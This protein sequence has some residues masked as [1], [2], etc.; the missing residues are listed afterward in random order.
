MDWQLRAE[1]SL[2][3]YNRD[4]DSETRAT[5]MLLICDDDKRIN[6]AAQI[7]RTTMWN[8]KQ[9]IS[10]KRVNERDRPVKYVRAPIRLTSYYE[11]AYLTTPKLLRSSIYAIEEEEKVIESF[12]KNA[13]NINDPKSGD[14]E[15]WP[16]R[17]F[18]NTTTDL[19]KYIYCFSA[20]KALMDLRNN[21]DLSIAAHINKLNYV[22]ILPKEDYP[23]IQMYPDVV[24]MEGMNIYEYRHSQND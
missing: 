15:D 2:F 21:I 7:I 16:C 10:S 3:Y 9:L 19:L 24:E 1:R 13:P 4:G 12:R 11:H 20:A 18:V 14:Y 5:G 17:Y 8:R 22:I 23:I 6:V